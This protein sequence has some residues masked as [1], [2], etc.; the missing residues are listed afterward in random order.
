MRLDEL[1]EYDSNNRP[2]GRR[3]RREASNAERAVRGI[4][5][6]T[7]NGASPINPQDMTWHAGFFSYLVWPIPE[8]SAL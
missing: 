2:T 3:W 5:D 7:G 8:I 6:E 4:L 1:T